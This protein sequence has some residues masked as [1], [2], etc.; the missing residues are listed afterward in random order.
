MH[1]PHR[2]GNRLSVIILGGQDGLVS[3]LGLL[4]GLSAAT[5]STRIVIAGGLAMIFAETLSMAAVA[6]TSKMAERDHY[7]AEKR[8]ENKEVRYKSATERQEIV[9]SIYRL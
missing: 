1:E 9:Q 6:Y 4:L 8:L 5:S 3:I 7:A 2:N